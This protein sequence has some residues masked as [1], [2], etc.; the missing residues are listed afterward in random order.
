MISPRT[1]QLVARIHKWLGLI[2]GA[3][4]V[5]WTATGLFFATF[6]I[7]DVHGDKLVHPPGHAEPMDLSRVKLSSTEALAAVAEDRPF[8]VRLRPLAG[9]PVYEIQAQ[10]GVFLVSAD[11]GEVLSPLSE[12]LARK[13]VMA[14][15][16]GPGALESMDQIQEAPRES[17]VKGRVWAAHFAG[18]GHPTLYV[19][20]TN[21]A[22]SSPRA[23][24]WRVYDFFWS[25]H[26]MDWGP[27]RDNFNTPWIVAAAVLALS[28]V[29]FG[30]VLLIHRFT[31]G[32]LK[33][34][35]T[36]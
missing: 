35:P 28:T 11:T 22:V 31:R 12:E 6:H 2:V 4:L 23:D 21:G 10:I 33:K 36:S 27:V 34:E 30:A 16:A 26:I 7:D 13:V 14:A 18:D 29:L 1:A 15:W 9:D 8:E 24:L 20:A 3:Q 25:L 5:I 32:V 19:S 17:S